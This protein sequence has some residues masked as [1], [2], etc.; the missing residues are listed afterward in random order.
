MS[1]QPRNLTQRQQEAL[2]TSLHTAVSRKNL[3]ETARLIEARANVNSREDLLGYTPLQTAV[4]K[5][6]PEG[7]HL[8][9]QH[10]ANI[11]VIEDR[12]ELTFLTRAAFSQGHQLGTASYIPDDPAVSNRPVSMSIRIQIENKD[13]ILQKALDDSNLEDIASLLEAGVTLSPKEAEKVYYLCRQAIRDKRN[14]TTI[15]TILQHL[16]ITKQQAQSFLYDASDADC[17]EIVP[18]LIKAGI[19]VNEGLHSSLHGSSVR[20]LQCFID[21]GADKNRGLTF[22]VIGKKQNFVQY[23]TEAGADKDHGL[24]ESI[25]F[26]QPQ[27]I[28]YF[29]S[30]GANSTV[31]LET[32]IDRNK[33]NAIQALVAVGADINKG[34]NIALLR[35]KEKIV[36]YFLEN[37]A[38]GTPE[39]LKSALKGSNTKL[40]LDLLKK[41]MTPDL[42]MLQIALEQNNRTIIEWFVD[43]NA[44]SQAEI[45]HTAI[46]KE[47]SEMTLC[48]LFD[49]GLIPSQEMIR[50]AFQKN[51]LSF[52]CVGIKR[53]FIPEI[54]VW[55][56][57]VEQDVVDFYRELISR[58]M[59]FNEETGKELLNFLIEK[60]K[61]PMI[62]ELNRDHSIT[63]NPEILAR[64]YAIADSE[65][66][67]EFAVIAGDQATAQQLIDAGADKTK[68]LLYAILYRKPAFIRYFA[69]AGADKNEGL[70][71]A[72]ENRQIFAITPLIEAGADKQTGLHLAIESG[73]TN[74]AKELIKAGAAPDGESLRLAITHNRDELVEHL[75]DLGVQPNEEVMRDAVKIDSLQKV[76]TLIDHGGVMDPET[77]LR[78]MARLVDKKCACPHLF[79]LQRPKMYAL[80]VFYDHAFQPLSKIAPQYLTKPILLLNI[81][82]YEAAG[83]Y[84]GAIT[85]YFTSSFDH[86]YEKMA[87]RFTLVRVMVDDANKL[88]STMDRVRAALPKLPLLHWALNGHGG[89]QAIGLSKNHLTT[90]TGSV[91]GEIGKRIDQHG[92]ASLWGCLNGEDDKNLA[93]IF[94]KYT[95]PAIVFASPSLVSSIAPYTFQLTPTTPVFAPFFQDDYGKPEPSRAY[96]DG[97][98]VADGYKLPSRL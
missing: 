24:K 75:L 21:L 57:A 82:D 69:I 2:D 44:F 81:A 78:L 5:K 8:L 15:N 85:Q 41:G 74:I 83:P 7:C 4:T 28:P 94:S 33:L 68:G 23:L 46:E 49:K 3:T 16:N 64:I 10:G 66:K 65:Q 60:G 97:E 32:A 14:P 48:L 12:Q 80:E 40:A 31:G 42:E 13:R 1:I 34:L 54:E 9:M 61:L 47:S 51:N 62:G 89:P 70:E 76:R 72:I 36:R 93:E 19:D 77:K 98:L 55:K 58:G 17:P 35:G 79:F 88:V 45:L 18:T 26:D 73:A 27:F 67:L 96:R 20:V 11:Q 52:L 90:D 43:N 56:R 63:Y 84:H 39:A 50:D 22:A 30:V 29:L 38:I 53:G 95:F 86:K 25:A 37:G 59:R 87:K 91:M 71:Y 92:T 6:W